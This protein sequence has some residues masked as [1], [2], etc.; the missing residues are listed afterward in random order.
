MMRFAATAAGLL[1]AGTV[2]AQDRPLIQPIR[3]VAVTYRVEGAAASVV[4]GGIPN[5]L[6]LS[7]DAERQRLRAEP[8][9]RSQVII[10]DLHARTALVMDTML[11]SALTLPMRAS[12]LQPLTLE[13]ARLTRREDAV[14]A[15]LPC[16]NWAIQSNRGNGV[17]CFTADGVPLRADGDVD[18]RHGTFTASSVS[19]APLSDS[20]F[21]VPDEFLQLS[22]PKLGRLK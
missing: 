12:D 13:G 6:R 20:L 16:T 2:L 7:W 15:G 1:A 18:G 19:Y 21:R 5:A 4:P 17:V 9:G 11:R 3:D 10:V 14:I 8:E 22:F